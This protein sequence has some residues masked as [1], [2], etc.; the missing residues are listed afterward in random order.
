MSGL[1]SQSLDET[2][3]ID[4][5]YALRVERGMT[6]SLFDFPDIQLPEKTVSIQP[7]DLEQQHKPAQ[8]DRACQTGTSLPTTR[9]V[10]TLLTLPPE[11]R[12][13]IYRFVL[14]NPDNA[15]EAVRCRYCYPRSRLELRAQPS[16]EPRLCFGLQ[17]SVKSGKFPSLL[18]LNRQT[19]FETT[20]LLYS[21]RSFVF[22]TWH[23]F[24][25]WA[26]KLL[27]RD[28]TG[29]EELLIRLGEV[30]IHL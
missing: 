20:K 23:C 5:R 14:N 7:V 26:E 2:T 30:I 15:P 19:Y 28:R 29:S 4:R 10:Q 16:K 11:I 18:V 25:G 22:C 9:P 27:Q 12:E 3:A 24:S 17:S 6:L 8:I 1:W 13:R 21:G